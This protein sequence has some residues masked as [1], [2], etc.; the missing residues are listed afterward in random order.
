MTAVEEESGEQGHHLPADEDWPQGFGEA[1]W[2]PI[3]TA[4][5]VAAIYIGAGVYILGT[6]TDLTG[7]LFG[8]G[9]VVLGTAGFLVGLYGWLYHG[10]VSHYWSRAVGV[11]DKFRWGMWLFLGS[12]IGT[13]SAGFT[14]YFFIRAGPWPPGHLPDLVSSLVLV[15]SV[16]LVASSVTL[17]FAHWAL[18]ND[19]RTRFVQLLGLTLLL[20]IVFVLGQLWE[21]YEFIVNEGFTITQGAY[22]SGF[23]GLT[24]LHGLHVTLGVVL[25]AILL[26]RSRH[27]HYAADRHASVTTVSMYWHFVDAVWIF[28]VVTLYLGATVSV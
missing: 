23:F 21:Y 16:I 28:L 18:R 27:G 13:F 8:V 22:A 11:S 20:G 5:G 1:S 14:Y 12:E 6:E 7:P 3:L 25:L 4:L 9:L 2:W 10:F 19:D 24:G 15:N 17:H 26:V